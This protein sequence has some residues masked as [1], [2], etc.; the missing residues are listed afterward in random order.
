MLTAEEARLMAGETSE[1]AVTRALVLVEHAAKLGKRCIEVRDKF[2]CSGDTN[3]YK[4]AMTIISK[5][6]Y[7][8]E[9][10]WDEGGQFV[11]MGTRISW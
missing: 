7:K 9:F 3:K 5:L 2:F 10:F 11:D 4:E 1:E 8:A 6:G